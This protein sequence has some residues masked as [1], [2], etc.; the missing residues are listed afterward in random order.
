M[1]NT[2]YRYANAGFS[3]IEALITIVVISIALLGIAKMQA[4]GTSDTQ[5]SRVQS[6]I[7]MQANSLAAS[8]HSNRSFWAVAGSAPSTF[9]ASGTTINDSSSKLTGATSF[10][11]V[12][13]CLGTSVSCSPAQT[14]AFD[15]WYWASNLNS[16]FP[17]YA[18]TVKCTA[19]APV[20]CSINIQWTENY[21]AINKTALSTTG[22]TPSFTL[23]VQP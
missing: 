17:T 11:S 16:K 7:A 13:S 15:V 22:S 9:T 14:A 2:N 5:I 3:M 23:L 20:N 10:T 6:L 12:T 8:M 19:T 1:L 21:V 4:A 18:A